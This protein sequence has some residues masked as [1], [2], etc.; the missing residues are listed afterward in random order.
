[1]LPPGVLGE[2]FV[3][4]NTVEISPDAAG[5]GWYVDAS[6]NDPAFDANGTAPAG[7]PA[8]NHEDLLTTVL[9][10]MGH[11]AGQADVANATSGSNL[12]DAVLPLGTRRIDALDQVFANGTFV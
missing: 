9:H 5:Y 10:E 6:A 11:L 12:M 1:V 2:T 4:S 8:A 3:Q 7:S